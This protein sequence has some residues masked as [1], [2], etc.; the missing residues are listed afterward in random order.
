MG[1]ANRF[2]GGC[3]Q[4]PDTHVETARQIVFE[5]GGDYIFT[6]KDNQKSLHQTVAGLLEKQ[7]F[8]PGAHSADTELQTRA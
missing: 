5:G 3:A 1:M 2:D 8:S 6:L 7:A 4:L